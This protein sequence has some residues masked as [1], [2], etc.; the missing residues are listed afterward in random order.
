MAG[1]FV[2][3]M[4]TAI[5]KTACVIPWT[6]F[7]VRPD[8]SAHFCCDV[9]PNLKVQGRPGNLSRDSL[10]DLWNADELVQV[11][12][13]MA[14]GEKPA[15]CSACWKQEAKGGVS[16]RLLINPVYRNL[17]GGL[18]VE[19]LSNEGAAT[20]YR[21]ERRPDWFVFE[22]GNVCN[23]K[24]RSCNPLSS[25]RVA[26]DRI[27]VAW[28]GQAPA[29]GGSGPAWFKQIDKLAEMI[30]G[31]GH[32][33]AMLSLMG[34][35]P[36]L[37]DHTW[38]L[39]D[40]LVARGV[41]P[42]IYVGLSTNGQQRNARLEGLA[43]HFRGFNVSVSIDGYGKLNDYLRHG[44]D[45]PKLVGN[46]DWLRAIPNVDVAIVPTLQNCNVLDMPAL[47]R[48]VDALDLPLAYNALTE[49]ARL[50]PANLP[51]TVR[52]IAVR[53]L[54]AYLD[55]ECK[56]V[57]RGVVRAYCE[58]IEEPGD[59]FDPDLF[60]EFATFTNDL[61]ADR[62][63]SLREAAPEL[64]SLIRA[65][66]V[67][68]P[69][70]RRH[71]APEAVRSTFDPADLLQRVNRTVSPL[72]VIF[73]TGDAV[74]T[75]WYFQSAA[76]Q[77]AE[78]DARLREHDHPG[79][80]GSRAV[81]DY[82]SHYGRMTRVLRAAL[83]HAAVYACDIDPGAVRYCAEELGAFPIV[84]GWHPDEEPLP[85]DLD[86]IVCISL[87]THTTLEHWRRT[88]RAWARML[89]P[90][91]AVAFTYL[92]EQHLAPWLAGELEHY[93]S[94]QPEARAAVA[95]S[96]R[97]DGFGFAPLTAM[98]GDEPSYGI[99]FA[100]ADVVRREVA[101]AGLEVI[102]MPGDANRQFAQDLVLARRP[103]GPA[104][105]VPERPVVQH[106]VSVVALYDPRCY[107]PDVPAEGDHGESTWA[108]LTAADSSGALP[109]EL[110]FGDPRVAELREA[111][112]AL[113][114]DH[115]IDA[116]CYLYPWSA[117]G[118]RWD[119]PFRDLVASGRPNFPFCI[120]I[121]A[122]NGA[123]I[124][125]A[126]AGGIFG[127]F[128]DALGDERYVRVDGRPFLVVRDL[129]SLTEARVVAARWRSAA[130]ER[131]IAALHLCAV[132]PAYAASPQDVGFDSF[133][134][135]PAPAGDLTA[136]AAAA[137]V[138]PPP[139]DR[140]FQRVTCRR[141]AADP[142]AAELYELHLYSTIDATR[143][144]GEKL[145]FVDAWND[146]T[147]GCYLEPDD[148]DGRAAL[149][150][151]RRAARGPAS[152]LVLLRRLR[153]ALGDVGAPASAALGELEHVVSIHERTRDRLLASVEAALGY[154]RPPVEM[155][156]RA[157]P[158][159]SR[160]LPPSDGHAHVDYVAGS[161]GAALAGHEAIVL[162]GNELRVMGWA[163]AGD[164][165]PATVEIFLALEA[166][167]A[168][169]D[170]I[171]RA[172]TRLARP[173]VVAAFP[174][175]PANCGFEVV[176]D[177]DGLAPG[178]YRVAIVQRTPDATY[179]DASAVIVERERTSCSNG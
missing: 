132:R 4:G 142:R 61:D 119:A 104:A 33:T 139:A 20:G 38:Q 54:R 37:I 80:A 52:L 47:L 174:D 74:R 91:G 135:A 23:L 134:D 106:D 71:V 103:S 112:A 68:W 170:R 110:G 176:A 67:E 21:L 9:L 143:R 77:L 43:P 46:L 126:S 179:R 32:E 5:S 58:I 94:Y 30:A 25:S 111:Q 95:D 60:A 117:A 109:T 85:S 2:R 158:V 140:Y 157:V 31:A 175:F 129:L 40:E 124:D 12:S 133:L 151:T 177:V 100:T 56:P 63:E 15:S 8:G 118:P 13:A 145:V 44:A 6:N 84:T 153:D 162:R 45:W 51:P 55:A 57:N 88:L 36:F 115:G 70:D 163:H 125:P 148:R 128:A 87:L 147:R 50:R 66:G 11:R 81:A 72:D 64:V 141:D 7:V 178:T 165:A 161:E 167:D 146:W 121:A 34:G 155:P 22:L 127:G 69:H 102:A 123:M 107:A 93:G 156:L 59:A 89:R 113:A 130:A 28:T 164:Y 14:R 82:A 19:K 136:A 122:E 138:M 10:D 159:P 152:G 78:I 114:R 53:R 96:L 86:A 150:A 39:L 108:K 48:F 172:G 90:G 131:G 105:V 120:M 169:N 41:A 76:D 168:S 79:L 49:P 166:A 101:A 160:Q 24:C 116:F 62:G 97:D 18:A 171:F 17:G 92:S 98:Y 99:A 29:A 1:L 83:P 149:L 173:D 26:A 27:Q 3:S 35:E 137:L 16:R 154:G 144:R 75:N 73:T 65:A 42:S